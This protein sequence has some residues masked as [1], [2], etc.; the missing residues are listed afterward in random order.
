MAKLEEVTSRKETNRASWRER[1]AKEC[2]AKKSKE[3]PL[4]EIQIEGNCM[5]KQLNKL[6]FLG[7]SREQFIWMLVCWL[8]ERN[9]VRTKKSPAE[10]PPNIPDIAQESIAAI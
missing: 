2:L 5:R 10:I 6:D 9:P 3:A 1:L 8:A 4:I 7:G